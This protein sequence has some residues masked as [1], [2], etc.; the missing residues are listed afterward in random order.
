MLSRPLSAI[1]TR[2]GIHYAWVILAVTF[3]T[4]LTT[5]GA[6]GIPGALILP[7]TQE[8]GWDTAQISSALAIRL[9]LFGLM[10]PFAAA[11]IVRYGVRRTVIL[12]ITLIVTGLVG[13][14]FMD[15][16]WHLV[17]AW[18][19][20]V[21]IGTGMTALVLSATV[22]NR[23]FVARRGLVIGI[24]A[25]STSTGQLVFLPMTTSL[26]ETHGWRVAVMPPI[27]ALT[28]VAILMLLFMRNRPSD[29]GL[30]PYGETAPVQPAQPAPPRAPV[31]RAFEVLGEAAGTP[32]FWILY[33]T[34]FV[35]G[36]ST[37]G[38]VQTHFIAFCSDFGVAPVAAAGVLAAM[39]ICDIFGTVGSGWL[40]DRVAPGKLLCWYYGLRGLALL[41]LPI[42]GFTGVGLGVFAVF[43]GL[44]WI[45]TV[46]PTLKL[47]NAAFGR[48]KAPIVFGWIFTAHQLGAATAAFGA[49]LSRTMLTTYLPAFYI[50]GA[51]CLAAACLALMARPPASTPSAAPV[52][53]R[54]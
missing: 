1:L 24:L 4:A 20:V 30:A 3:V 39:G 38:L 46:P 17:L 25:A 42:S 43:Y 36:L 26:A 52:V 45:A 53:D 14:L 5:A 50:A 47:A 48:E 6:V 37:N 41:F 28:C 19:I 11:L 34:F 10:A 29:V 31:R 32:I 8:F 33:G 16:V 35:C 21:G 23:W 22:A 12:A 54:G 40:S 2:Y 18:G 7:L 13:A 44:D 49:G 51:A 27:G 15:R 9:L